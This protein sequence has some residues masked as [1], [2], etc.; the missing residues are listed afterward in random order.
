MSI[1]IKDPETE[2][3]VRELA[4]R[5]NADPEEAVRRVSEDA[6]ARGAALSVDEVKIDAIIRQFRELPVADAR[7][8]EEIVNEI[9]AEVEGR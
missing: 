7:P 2:R 4:R 9:N 5:L 8:I 6:L 1:E 3:V